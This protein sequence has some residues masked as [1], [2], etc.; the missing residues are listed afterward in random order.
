MA[1]PGQPPYSIS[2]RGITYYRERLIEGRHCL[3]IQ[4]SHKNVM[5]PIPEAGDYLYWDPSQG[6]VFPLDGGAATTDVTLTRIG[7]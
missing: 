2:I 6:F 7:G 3:L 1:D 4:M 5:P